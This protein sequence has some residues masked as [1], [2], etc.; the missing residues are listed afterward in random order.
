M[1]DVTNWAIIGAGFIATRFAQDL[2][3]LDGAD[4]VGV[5]SCRPGEAQVFAERFGIERAFDSYE[6]LVNDSGVDVV[7]V[8]TPH[9]THYANARLA[10]DAGKSVLVEK[11]LTLNAR[12]AAHLV[13]AARSK[14]VFLMEAMWTRFLPHMIKIRSLLDEGAIGDIVAVSAEQGLWFDPSR[15]EHRLYDKA[16]GG[17]ALMDMGVYP[18][19]FVVSLLGEPAS[20]TAVADMTESGVDGQTTVVMQDGQGRHGV[21]ATTLWAEAPNRASISGTDGRI[22]IGNMWM[23]PSEFSLIGRGEGALTSESR[24]DFPM[25]VEGNG[26]RFEAAEVGRCIREGRIESSLMP[27]SFSLSVMRVMDEIRS[28]IG[29]RYDSDDLA[30]NG[31]DHDLSR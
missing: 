2:A 5:A 28:Q 3:L 21:A 22:E 4:L 8:A 10:I 23:T 30:E 24:T 13:D 1:R 31:A 9:S 27:H 19:S 18:V 14:G 17:G 6:A 29:L 26:L 16:L 15:P 11:P 7:Y 12:E 25:D 20:I